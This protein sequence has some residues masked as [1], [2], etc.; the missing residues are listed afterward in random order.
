MEDV[1][2]ESFPIWAYTS[3]D[4]SPESSLDQLQIMY[5]WNKREQKYVEKVRTRITQKSITAQELAKIQDGTE[6]TFAAF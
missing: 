4:E 5:D 1:D 6:K 2:G 3:D